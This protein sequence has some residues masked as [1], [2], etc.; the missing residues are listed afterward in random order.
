MINLEKH[1][2]T[3][4]PEVQQFLNDKLEKANIVEDLFP[5]TEDDQLNQ[6][7]FYSEVIRVYQSSHYYTGRGEKLMEEATIYLHRLGYAINSS[8]A[9]AK[10]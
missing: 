1:I 8:A 10:A 2:A 4:P 6:V 3:L 5:S 9:T 7:A